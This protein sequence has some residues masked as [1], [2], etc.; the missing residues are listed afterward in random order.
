MKAKAAAR[1]ICPCRVQSAR[2]LSYQDCC[3]PI[4]QGA[5]A[6]TAE[7]LMRSRYSAFALQLGEYLLASWHP[8]TRS[9]SIEF[10]RSKWLRLDVHAH[11]LLADDRASVRFTAVYRDAF[12]AHK[13]QENSEFVREA[14]RWF[15]LGRFD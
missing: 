9:A 5:L 1:M 14:G 13:L 6:A 4:H 15:Y 7:A 12:G 3:E 11:Q 8:S 10:D 2:E